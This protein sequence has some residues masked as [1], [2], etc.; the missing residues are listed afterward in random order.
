[1]VERLLAE[2]LALGVSAQVGLEPVG[3]DDRDEGFDGV[4]RRAGLGDVLHDVPSSSSEDGVD[5]R[6]TIRWRLNLDVVD[7]LHQPRSCLRTPRIDFSDRRRHRQ[8]QTHHHESS[9][10]DPPR[11]RDNLA[12]AAVYR[13]FRQCSI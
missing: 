10:A 6:D 3:V 1:M 9:V 13:L 4:Q 5:G 8:R 2:R 12:A 11:R 7:W